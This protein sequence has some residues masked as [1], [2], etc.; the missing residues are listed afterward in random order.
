VQSNIASHVLERQL[1]LRHNTLCAYRMRVNLCVRTRGHVT[2][3]IEHLIFVLCDASHAIF[4]KKLLP[5]RV[6][7]KWNRRSKK[8]VKGN[9]FVD[10]P[11]IKGSQPRIPTVWTLSMILSIT[12]ITVTPDMET[13]IKSKTPAWQS[14]WLPKM[15]DKLKANRSKN[16][17]LCSYDT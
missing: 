5:Y 12:V 13:L 10:S 14:H 15:T 9:L 17:I 6:L 16:L 7:F 4:I 8:Q 2:V 11:Y 1:W 3:F